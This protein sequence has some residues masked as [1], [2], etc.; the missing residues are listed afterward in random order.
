MSFSSGEVDDWGEGVERAVSLT[1][2]AFMQHQM[3]WHLDDYHC[4]A[5]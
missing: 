2:S 1:R 3:T 4:F 5:E